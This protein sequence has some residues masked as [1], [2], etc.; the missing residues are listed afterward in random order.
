[1]HAAS[2]GTVDFTGWAGGYGNL[3][4]IQHSDGIETY[5]AHNSLIEAHVGDQV[6]PGDVIALSGATGNATGPHVHFEVRVNGNPIDPIPF[7]QDK[8]LN[9]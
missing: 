6:Q 8:G 5:Y 4:R 3:V 1:M 2:A 7:L 9:P